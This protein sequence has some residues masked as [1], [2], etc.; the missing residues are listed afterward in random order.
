MGCLPRK[1]RKA[2]KVA[3]TGA[4]GFVGSHLTKFL[5]ANGHTV[6][7][8]GRAFFADGAESQLLAAVNRADAVVN[9]AGAPIAHRWTDSYKQLLYSS[10]ITLTTKLVKAIRQADSRKILVSA[11]AVG[12]YSTEGVHDEYSIERGQGFLADLCN[13]WELEAVNAMKNARVV[14]VRLGLVMGKDGGYFARASRLS[15]FAVAMTIGRGQQP[16]P[17]IDIRDVCRSILFLLESDDAKGYY[18][19]T[20]PQLITQRE[21]TD[22]VKRHRRLLLS[23]PI[24]QFV[25]WMVLGEAAEVVVDGQRVRPK[26]LLEA[27]YQFLSPTIDGFLDSIAGRG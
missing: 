21:F 16:F 22:A 24:P 18:N 7:P 4:T 2:M 6:I 14:I 17:W 5:V 9:L 25:V 19:L 12:Y 13:F 8:L 3:I 11:S 15:R 10:R 1:D 27:G 23:L 20:A 26:R